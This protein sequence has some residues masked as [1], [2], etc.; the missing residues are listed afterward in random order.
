MSV[1]ALE[2]GNT[3]LHDSIHRLSCIAYGVDSIRGA[4]GGTR[5]LVCRPDYATYT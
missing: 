5:G 1:A 4:E 3:Y 2:G